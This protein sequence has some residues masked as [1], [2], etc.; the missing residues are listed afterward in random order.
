M[1]Q[2]LG[3][4]DTVDTYAMLLTVVAAIP[5]QDGA[6]IC[7]GATR[8]QNATLLGQLVSLAKFQHDRCRVYYYPWDA[9]QNGCYI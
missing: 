4:L 3:A 8:S 9:G 1:K 5:C 6:D 7:W 2:N